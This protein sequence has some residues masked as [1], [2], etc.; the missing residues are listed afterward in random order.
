MD[1]KPF[2]KLRGR[3]VEKYGTIDKFSLAVG[4]STVQISKKLNEKAGFSKD[5]I[6]KWSELLDISAEDVGECFFM[7][8]KSKELNSQV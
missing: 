7:L 3:I 1:V 2:S 6:T 5:D 8:E 4:M